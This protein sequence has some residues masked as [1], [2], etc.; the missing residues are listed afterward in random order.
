MWNNQEDNK[1]GLIATMAAHD[2]R[3]TAISWVNNVDPK[4]QTIVLASAGL[5]AFLNLWDVNV[6]D[7]V[8]KIKQK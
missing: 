8:F 7:S 1:D 5:D 3:I 6:D 4:K 2:E